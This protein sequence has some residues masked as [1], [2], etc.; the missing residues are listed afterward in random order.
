MSLSEKIWTTSLINSTTT[1][2]HPSAP[3]FKIK[4]WV[5]P[6]LTYFQHSLI[7]G[8]P[9]KNRQPNAYLCNPCTE[10]KNMTQRRRE[11]KEQRKGAL[12]RR[13]TI[14]LERPKSGWKPFAAST[15][16]ICAM[17][18][19]TGIITHG[20]QQPGATANPCSCAVARQK[21]YGSNY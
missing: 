17:K 11:E 3:A 9:L 21:E 19:A 15:D 7:K 18:G 6:A 5:W 12:I 1:Q 2:R 16:A 14:C 8:W 4:T 13:Y 20:A 10:D